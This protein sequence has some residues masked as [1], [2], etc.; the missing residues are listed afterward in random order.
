MMKH[1]HILGVAGTFMGGIAQIAQFSGYRVTGQDIGIYPP[2]SDQ[3]KALGLEFF[4][5]Y[6]VATVES[7]NPD[8]LIVGNNLSRG[9]PVLEW[10]LSN[11]VDI[12]SGPLWLYQN[13]LKN[14]RVL[15][16]SGTHGK[17][18]T[19]SLLTWLLESCGLNPSYL[20]GGVPGNFSS[21][22]RL[23]DSDYFVIEADEY[24][25]A[26]FDKRSK[27]IHYHPTE[28]IINN[29]EFDHADIFRD[30]ED[31][32][33]QFHHLL[34]IL[35]SAATV[36]YPGADKGVE[37]VIA[38][39]LWSNSIAIGSGCDW[40][41]K[42]V[43]LDFSE[44]EI[45]FKDVLKGTVNWDLMGEHNIQNALSAFVCAEHLGLEAEALITA[46]KAFKA[47]KRRLQHLGNFQGVDV[48]DDFAHHPTA[49]SKTIQG[50]RARLET[51]GEGRLVGVLELRSFTMR[52]GVHQQSLIDALSGVDVLYVLRPSSCSWD[53]DSLFGSVS[54]VRL[55][56]DV[57]SIVS[58]ITV[59]VKSGD[60][61][62]IMS[63]GGFDGFQAKLVDELK[64]S[65]DA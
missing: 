10:A 13:V 57:E 42:P 1:V 61:V 32:Y 16:V 26:I 46:M 40:H 15:A 3:L 52:N 18:T 9:N 4:S 6:D 25:T 60:I 54:G 14:K 51:K 41:I 34:K 23:T 2:M 20:I 58:K 38:Q 62:V 50:V 7:L 63:N 19:S 28:L 35:P 59:D 12:I 29:I 36:I 47:P 31:V 21:S 27:F 39:G 8:V 17:T 5:G 48:Y 53:V 24:D 22:A 49:I 65:V 30:V 55:L 43:A 44:F 64:L 45:Y 11:R 56:D 37:A 33:R